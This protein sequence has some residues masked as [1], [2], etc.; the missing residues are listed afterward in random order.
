M[1]ETSEQHTPTH[2]LLHLLERNLGTLQHLRQKL[3]RPFSELR[4]RID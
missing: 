2:G 3:E 4:I 1:N